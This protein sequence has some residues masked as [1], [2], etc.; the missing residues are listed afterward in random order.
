M[1]D[2]TRIQDLGAQLERIRAEL[3]RVHHDLNNPLSVIA[4][5]AELLDVL[6]EGDGA[7]PGVREAI[8]DLLL[9]VEQLTGHTDRLLAVRGLLNEVVQQLDEAS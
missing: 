8:K 5:N 3:S 6:T 9:A 2:A 1:S 4:G 7:D